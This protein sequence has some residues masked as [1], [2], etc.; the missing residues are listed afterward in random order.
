MFCSLLCRLSLI[1]VVV[2][3]ALIAAAIFGILHIVLTLTLDLKLRNLHGQF[4]VIG[5]FI[6]RIHLQSGSDDL[7]LVHA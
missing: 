7:I 1:S 4:C 3:I 2:C 6:I 5:L